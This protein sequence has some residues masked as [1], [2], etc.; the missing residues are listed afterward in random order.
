V[1][2]FEEVTANSGADTLKPGDAWLIVPHGGN[3]QVFLREGKGYTIA[4]KSEGG[5]LKWKDIPESARSPEP[6]AVL[7]QAKRRKN[8]RW[9]KFTAQKTG[10][11]RIRVSNGGLEVSMGF[12]VHPKK[13]FKISFLFLQDQSGSQPTRRSTFDPS[14]AAQWIADLNSVFGPQANI[15]FELGKSAPVVLSG[16]PAVVSDADAPALEKKKD[17]APINI[18]LAGTQIKSSERDFPNGFYAINEK[19]IVVKDQIA[20]TPNA[21]PMLKTMAHEIAH[22]LN[23]HRKA[24]TPGH[25][26]YKTCGYLS[27]VLNTLDGN[28]IKIPHQRVLDWNPW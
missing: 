12:S 20:S 4:I 15:W 21:K 2:R 18:F 1:A 10:M 26:Y 14:N 22:L 25:D 27:D 7:A 17:A 23:Y 16:L 6:G 19:L 3:N 13:T 5:L 24:S 11:G 28:D 8:D 9:L